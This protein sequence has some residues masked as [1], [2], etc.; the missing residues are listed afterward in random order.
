MATESVLNTSGLESEL[1]GTAL[2]AL[3]S[4]SQHSVA[5]IC[6]GDQIVLHHIVDGSQMLPSPLSG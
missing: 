3:D 1:Q 5:G 4:P 2:S 6:R